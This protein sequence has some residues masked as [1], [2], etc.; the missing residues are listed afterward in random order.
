MADIT[1]CVC[2]TSSEGWVVTYQGEV[3]LSHKPSL[4][5]QRQEACELEAS[6]GYIAR[7]CLQNTKGSSISSGTKVLPYLSKV[8][9]SIP[10]AGKGW[11]AD[12]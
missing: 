12:C 10:K 3:L 11:A 9:G 6:L 2:K 8:L 1:N 7:L 4:D 5:W